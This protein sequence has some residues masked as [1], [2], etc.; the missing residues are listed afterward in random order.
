M[1]EQ[2]EFGS[3]DL[4]LH[5]GQVVVLVTDG[6]TESAAEDEDQFGAER[7]VAYLTAERDC[8][9]R[10]IADGICQAAIDFAGAALQADDITAVVVKV[11]EKVAGSDAH[12][13]G[14]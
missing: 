10:H 14:L 5:A 7:L 6:V 9:A 12:S 1:F 8:P 2:S 3:C 4:A 11:G 13:L